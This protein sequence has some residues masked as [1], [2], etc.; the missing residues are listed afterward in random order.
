MSGAAP[1]EVA[2]APGAGMASIAQAADERADDDAPQRRRSADSRARPALLPWPWTHSVRRAAA[3]P[4]AAELA[5]RSDHGTA[6]AAVPSRA[7]SRPWLA[8]NGS[9]PISMKE[10]Y[11]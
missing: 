10:P 1:G 7:R 11:L 2:S 9:C 6:L 5:R 8:D 3:P 4:A